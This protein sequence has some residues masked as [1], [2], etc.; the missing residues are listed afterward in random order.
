M[1]LGTEQEVQLVT[2]VYC[3]SIWIELKD[4]NSI[5]IVNESVVEPFKFTQC[6]AYMMNTAMHAIQDW[7]HSYINTL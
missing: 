1:K 3:Y 2:L 4:G 7:L 6:T 5:W